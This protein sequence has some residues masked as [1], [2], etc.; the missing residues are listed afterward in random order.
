M[1]RKS[2]RSSARRITSNPAPIS[3]TPSSSSTPGLRQ[4]EREVERG[5]AAERRQQR[6][7]PLPLE[8]AR[9][10][11]EVERLDIGAVGESGVGHDRRRVRVDDDGAE[12][13]LPQDLERLTARVVELAR[14]PDHDRPRADHADRREVRPPWQG[15]RTPPRPRS[16]ATARR[17]AGP[18]RPPGGTA[19]TGRPAR[20]SRAPRRCRRRARRAS[21]PAPPPGL[22]A[23][24]WFCAVTRTRPVAFSSTGWFAPRWPNGSLK[25]SW[26]LASASSW[27]PRQMPKTGTRP[28]SVAT[29]STC[30]VSGSGSP[31]PFERTTPS[32]PLELV[33]SSSLPERP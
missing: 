15:P 33:R 12:S 22:T 20:G 9:D 18:G 29:V 1:S 27:W 21:P 13:V 28:S 19:P 24:P 23:K 10:A 3:S 25:V 32:K 8:H 2:S 7:G 26:P 5:L 17:R 4:L 11:V 6:V 31:G 14:L 30:A 16:R